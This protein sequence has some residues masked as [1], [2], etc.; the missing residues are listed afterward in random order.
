[1]LKD[2]RNDIDSDIKNYINLIY[3]QPEKVRNCHL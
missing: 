2:L 3:L 1:M